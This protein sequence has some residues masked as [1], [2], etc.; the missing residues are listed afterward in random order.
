[1]A[2]STRPISSSMARRARVTAAMLSRE[3]A[4]VTSEH[5]S[6]KRMDCMVSTACFFSLLPVTTTQ[7]RQL[8]PSADESIMVRREFWYGTYLFSTSAAMQ[9]L[10]EKSPRLMLTA[11]CILVSFCRNPASRV[12]ISA[13]SDLNTCSEPPRSA[14]HMVLPTSAP[15]SARVCCRLSSSTLCALEL[16]S[17]IIV[18]ALLLAAS[19]RRSNSSSS[20]AP[21][22]GTE[23]MPEKSALCATPCHMPT[24]APSPSRSVTASPYTS[25]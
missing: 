1:M 5:V 9:T 11:S 21:C 6:P 2:A 20:A 19:A 10:R 12:C 23:H 8:P 14:K 15:V 22:T 16:R 25:T 7:V 3:A 18:A 13:T 17:F 24:A 4:L